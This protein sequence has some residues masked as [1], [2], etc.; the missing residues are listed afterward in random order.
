M[1]RISSK[2]PND[3]IMNCSIK[4]I[5]INLSHCSSVEKANPF[6]N[7]SSVRQ[8]ILNKT[9]KI[10]EGFYILTT[11]LHLSGCTVVHLSPDELIN[12]L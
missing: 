7:R 6:S 2:S 12:N 4:G 9:R 5:N 8:E 11:N 1:D 10:N 3:Y